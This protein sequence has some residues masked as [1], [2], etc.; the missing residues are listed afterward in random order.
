LYIITLLDYR[1]VHL[2]VELAEM[3]GVIP[4]LLLFL[5]QVFAKEKAA[6]SGAT[7]V[8]LFKKTI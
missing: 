8:P 1:V 4:Q 5:L 6:L 7:K 3:G 2:L